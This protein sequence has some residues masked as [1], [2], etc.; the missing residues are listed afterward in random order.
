MVRH[1][2]DYHETTETEY[3]ELIKI[4]ENV[5]SWVEGKIINV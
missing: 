5:Y 4:A 2:D 1:P 3:K